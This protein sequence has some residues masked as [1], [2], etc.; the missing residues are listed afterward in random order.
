MTTHDGIEIVGWVS[1]PF[2]T[3]ERLVEIGGEG[4]DGDAPRRIDD[5]EVGTAG[6]APLQMNQR[7]R[8]RAL[9]GLAST[10]IAYC[11]LT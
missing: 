10:K 7:V 5:G 8:L 2:P 11:M 3:M 4:Q 1:I 9:D 6:R